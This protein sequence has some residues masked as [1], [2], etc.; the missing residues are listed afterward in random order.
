[1]GQLSDDG[2]WWWDGATWIATSQV[3]LPQLPPTELEQSGKL[4]IARR[5]LRKTGW[6]NWV[7]DASDFLTW[8]AMIPGYHVTGPALRDYRLWTLEQLAAATTYLLGPNEPILAAEATILPPQYIGDSSKRDLAVVV[9]GE[10]VLLLRID[11]LDGQPRWVVL[12]ARPADVKM[13]VRSFWAAGF[14]GGPALTVSSGNAKWLIR[15]VDDVWKPEL[16]LDAWRRGAAQKLV[17]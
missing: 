14:L 11:S 7:N 2:L 5:G 16:V 15:G 17:G 13:E 1:M 6:L 4:E 10:H 9:T 8:I 12:V 3:V